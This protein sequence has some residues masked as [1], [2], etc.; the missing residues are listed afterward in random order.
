[1]IRY[2]A[3]LGRFARV[4]FFCAAAL[5]TWADASAGMQAPGDSL[6]LKVGQ[7]IMVGFRGID[8]EQA[9]PVVEQIRNIGIG[10]VVLF[11]YDVQS[12]TPVRNIASPGQLQR[13]TAGLQ[14]SSRIPLLIAVDQEGGRVARL[15]PRHGFAAM[16]SQ[17]E[18]GRLDDSGRTAA[19]A[20][21]AA[22]ELRRCGINLNFAPVLDVNVNPA[23]PVIGK[24]ERSFSKSV[25]AVIRH[26]RSAVGA[27]R[28]SGV[29]CAVKHFPGHGSSQQDSHEG[30]TDVSATWRTFELTPFA[31][32]IE[33]GLCDM[34]MTA[35]I[36]NERLDPA[37][38][39]TLSVRVV[40]GILRDSLGFDGVVITDDLQMKAISDN[41]GLDAAVRLAIEAGNDILLFGNNTGSYDENIAAKAAESVERL[42]R[43]GVI[44][45]ER[46]DASFRRIMKLKKGLPR[47]RGGH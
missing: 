39:A 38:P 45:A 36:F 18:L 22:G 47:S 23:N 26:G 16:P 15:K 10:G 35:H 9:R 30:F 3:I 4:C 7:M 32:L 42:V 2:E 12:K 34:V 44:P 27:Y 33:Y 6:K 13:L 19:A 25:D 24:L 37:H 5:L 46:I 20:A 28:R 29:L 40:D 8:L 1:M 31:R 17:A 21:T 43:T 41:Y 14:K 11:D